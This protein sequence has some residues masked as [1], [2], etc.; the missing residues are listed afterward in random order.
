[1]LIT[2]V[3]LAP[4]LQKTNFRLEEACLLDKCWSCFYF[5]L[6]CADVPRIALVRSNRTMCVHGQKRTKHFRNGVL[7]WDVF[8]VA[9]SYASC[10][11]S[12]FVSIEVS[13]NSYAFSSVCWFWMAVVLTH[14]VGSEWLLY[15]LILLVLNDCCIDSF[16]SYSRK[17]AL[18]TRVRGNCVA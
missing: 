2:L 3:A 17:L 4:N 10:I 12:T 13:A 11:L 1:M 18:G 15:W 5:V 7:H 16:S 14:S 8:L 9:S 6:C